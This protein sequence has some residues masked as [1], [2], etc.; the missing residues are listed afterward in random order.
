MGAIP[1]AMML[2][3]HETG[4]ILAQNPVAAAL[5]GELSGH[6]VGQAFARLRT[7]DGE[8][9]TSTSSP[10]VNAVEDLEVVSGTELLAIRPDGRQIPVLVSAAPVSHPGDPMHGVVSSVSRDQCTQGSGPV[11]G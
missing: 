2:I 7:V 1:E 4:A 3:D 9:V 11:E 8:P 6:H 5:L 10:V